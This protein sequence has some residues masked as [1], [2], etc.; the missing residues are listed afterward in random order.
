M[1]APA[2]LSP[3]LPAEASARVK[4]A[5]GMQTK[6]DAH[7]ADYLNQLLQADP[8]SDTFRHQLD[9]GFALGRKE[10]AEATT[11][12]NRFTGQNFVGVEDGAAYQAMA[13]MRTLFAELNPASQGDLFSPVRI[14][15]I[16]LPWINKLARYLG[17]YQSAQTH[18]AAIQTQMIRAK[19]E[20]AQ[21]VA[22]M[23]LVR[24]QLR[25]AAQ[26][27]AGMA[28][29]LCQ[30]DLRLT[31]E[32]AG[33]KQTDPE[34]ARLF[35]QELLYYVRQNLNDVEAAQALNLNADLV[36][37]ELRKTGRETI[38]GCDRV[39]TLGMAAL[40]IAATLARATGNQMATQNMVSGAKTE[41]EQLINSTGQALN[42]HAEQTA[43]FGNDPIIGVQTLQQMF[44]QTFAAMDK[45][46][47]FRTE[48]LGNMHANHLLLC[49]MLKQAQQR[50][51]EA[52]LRPDQLPEPLT[53]HAVT[54]PQ[55][56]Q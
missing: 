33:L 9:A 31:Q 16:R 40:S 42:A 37:G 52:D 55:P 15:G 22:A 19:D 24:Q 8:A 23:E 50:L 29:Y 6:L 41:I 13:N 47:S 39:L 35:E 2:L 10:I 34:R 12:T 54:N 5:P 17:R 30:I 32:I 21:D 25:Q 3:V 11:L 1:S 48:A 20:I 4:L 14:L 18:M 45:I 26:N 36:L 44:S 46:D 7:L 27:L 56:A 51:P 38:T 43:R 53:S 28:Y 49:E